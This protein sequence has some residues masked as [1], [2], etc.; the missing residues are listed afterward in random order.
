MIIV[1]LSVEEASH[2]V[3]SSWECV[4]KAVRQSSAHKEVI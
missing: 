1:P 4:E 3:S 2:P